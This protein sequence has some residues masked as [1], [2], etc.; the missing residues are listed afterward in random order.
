MTNNGVVANDEFKIGIVGPISDSKDIADCYTVEHWAKVRKII[1]DSYSMIPMKLVSE[2]NSSGIILDTII[3]HLAEYD[4]IICDTSSNNPNVMFELGLRLAFDKPVIL[5]KDE[6]TEYSFDISLI[7][8]VEYTS[9]LEY[10]SMLKFQK[11][12]SDRINHIKNN[13][14]DSFL[15]H[16]PVTSVNNSLPQREVSGYDAFKNDFEKLIPLLSETKHLLSLENRNSISMI[17]NSAQVNLPSVSELRRL[18]ME[19]F[20]LD[21]IKKDDLDLN[22]LYEFIV[23]DFNLPRLSLDDRKRLRIRIRRVLQSID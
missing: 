14:T 20:S 12:L 8:H 10:A 6:L 23:T 2:S 22:A 13:G 15:S 7:E 16:F 3:Q 11:T 1:E 19:S 9:N 21:D 18:L 5:I 17:N 4:L